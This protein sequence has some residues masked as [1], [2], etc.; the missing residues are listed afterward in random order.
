M[1]NDIDRPL[2][3]LNKLKGREV[4]VVLKTS[5][6]RVIGTLLAFD[7]YINIAL[8]INGTPRFIKGDSITYI[9]VANPNIE[10]VKKGGKK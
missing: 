5:D 4:I 8:D 3:L 6:E 7:L 10:V 9:D 2:D 1:I